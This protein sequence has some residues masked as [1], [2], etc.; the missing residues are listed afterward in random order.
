[1]EQKN[2]SVVR[3]QVGYGRY[4]SA[5]ALAQFNQVYELLRV[6]IN[7]WQPAMKLIGKT[8]DG[9]KVTKRYDVPHPPYRRALAAGVVSATAQ[10]CWEQAVA[11]RGP[12]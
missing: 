4:E 5:A 7:H 12:V 6:W 2:Y 10:A 1:V 9:A 8:R 3:R 11:R